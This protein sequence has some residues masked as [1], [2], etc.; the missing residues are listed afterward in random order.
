MTFRIS[1]NHWQPPIIPQSIHAKMIYKKGNTYVKGLRNAVST[2][3]RPHGTVRR[4]ARASEQADPKHKVIGKRRT[5]I[6]YVDLS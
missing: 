3:V 2:H 5:N 4:S 6:T 1:P